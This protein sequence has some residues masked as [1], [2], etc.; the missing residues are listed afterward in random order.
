MQDRSIKNTFGTLQS[1]CNNKWGNI[2]GG[3]SAVYGSEDIGILGQ[4]CTTMRSLHQNTNCYKELNHRCLLRAGLNGDD[5]GIYFN[6]ILFIP[7]NLICIS[8]VGEWIFKQSFSNALNLTRSLFGLF[9][10]ISSF[11][12]AT[13]TNCKREFANVS[14]RCQ[15]PADNFWFSWRNA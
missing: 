9:R 4:V 6:S 8:L 13:I 15:G 2:G 1:T 11:N 5:Y 12:L 10:S 7:F 14:F 3:H